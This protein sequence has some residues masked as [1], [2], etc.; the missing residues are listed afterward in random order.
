[1]PH[2]PV[3]TMGGG[4]LGGLIGAF[5]GAVIGGS[6]IAVADSMSSRPPAPTDGNGVE[7]L[8]WLIT[9]GADRIGFYIAM[10]YGAGIGGIIGGIGGS[11][12]GAGLAARVSNTLTEELPSL[13]DS[14]PADVPEPPIESTDAELARLKERVAELEAEKRKD[15]QPKEE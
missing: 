15:D 8:T 3:K 13:K 12:L 9:S 6:I 14:R 4:C 5:L 11:V 1:M 10:L 7:G 2:E